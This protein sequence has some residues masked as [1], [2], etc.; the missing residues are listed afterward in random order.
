MVDLKR[1]ALLKLTG[2]AGLAG[3]V[4]SAVKAVGLSQRSG[5]LLAGETLRNQEPMGHDSGTGFGTNHPLYGSLRRLGWE[6]EA[7]RKAITGEMD[8]YI[9]SLR[10]VSPAVKVIMQQHASRDQQRLYDKLSNAVWGPG[11]QPQAGPPIF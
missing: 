2:G 4:D 3:M 6:H 1:R 7:R 11:P 9:A 10:S 8:P 5:P